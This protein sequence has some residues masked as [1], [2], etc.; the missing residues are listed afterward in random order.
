MPSCAAP[1]DVGRGVAVEVDVDDPG[2]RA[3]VF[4]HALGAVAERND[5]QS[6]GTG[7]D[8]C[9]QA[10]HLGVIHCLRVTLRRI[11]EFMMPVPLMQSRM[12]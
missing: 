11:H 10:V 12:P 2:P 7:R 8:A 3:A 4:E 1:E 6:F 5:Q 9:G